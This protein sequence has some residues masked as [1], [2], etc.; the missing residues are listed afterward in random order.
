M[1]V[2]ADEHGYYSFTYNTED[3]RDLVERKPDLYLKVLD[4]DGRTLFTS[5]QKI[6]YEAGRVEV[7]N[8]TID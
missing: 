5:E 1:D 2:Q 3:F 8:I 4:R 6:R 7:V